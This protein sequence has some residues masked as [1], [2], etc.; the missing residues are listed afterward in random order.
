MTLDN[1]ETVRRGYEAM[2][3]RDFEAA[4]EGIHPDVEWSDP[5]EMP[6]VR[7]VK[8][9]EAVK[10]VWAQNLEPF[11]KFR[12]E[13]LEFIDRGDVSFHAIKLTGTGRTSGA[14]VEMVWFQ[15][16]HNDAEGLAVRLENYLD[17]ERA[18]E[19]AGLPAPD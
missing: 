10:E 9:V 19:A 11:D 3:R 6:E 7:T 16:T 1:A 15:V 17:R 5:P 2:N 12:F 14:P 8:G 18:R 4:A 13:T